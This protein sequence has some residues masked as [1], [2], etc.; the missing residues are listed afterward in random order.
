MEYEGMLFLFNNQNNTTIVMRNM[1]FPIDIIW[2]NDNIVVDMAPAV[3]PEPRVDEENLVKY[4]T[5]K[6]ANMVLEL[7]SGGI[8]K[9]DIKIGDSISLE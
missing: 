2:L 7:L 6:S 9:Y 3:Q 8:E 4:Y 1:L 5:Q